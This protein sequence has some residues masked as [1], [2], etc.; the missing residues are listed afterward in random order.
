MI[1]S[2][3][4]VMKLVL[5]GSRDGCSADRLGGSQGRLLGVKAWWLSRHYTRS[6]GAGGRGGVR[7]GR[8]GAVLTQGSEFT[9]RIC[10]QAEGQG[11]GLKVP[12][13]TFPPARHILKWERGDFRKG[14]WTDCI[15]R[16]NLK[17]HVKRKTFKLRSFA[18]I[19]LVYS[20][21]VN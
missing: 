16:P 14:N 2:S 21:F 10:W 4:S 5:Q 3:R 7:W 20:Q 6:G 8:R 12:A 1:D 9:L 19:I 11:R 13:T 17:W 15:T 18:Q